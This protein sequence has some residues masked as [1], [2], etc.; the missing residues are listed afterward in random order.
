M[1]SN[2]Q[3][4]VYPLPVLVAQAATDVALVQH[5]ATVLGRPELNALWT[6][7]CGDVISDTEYNLCVSACAY[8]TTC[9]SAFA[10]TSL[11]GHRYVASEAEADSEQYSRKFLRWTVLGAANFCLL[12]TSVDATV[13]AH[14][15][16]NQLA[17]WYE[18]AGANPATCEPS[19]N[20]LSVPATTSWV[21]GRTFVFTGVHTATRA[22]L[23]QM[24]RAHG[25][26]VK[27]TVNGK[28]DFLVMGD[29]RGNDW[30]VT[31]GSKYQKVL[32][33][34]RTRPN[35]SDWIHVITE[36]QLR[37]MVPAGAWPVAPCGAPSDVVPETVAEDTD[38]ADTMYETAV[39]LCAMGHSVS[40]TR[41]PVSTAVQRS[42][43]RR[44]VEPPSRRVTRSMHARDLDGNTV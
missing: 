39:S 35:T 11:T 33:L 27:G 44:R 37:R 6:D 5:L 1:P 42:S 26:N 18:C 40:I 38:E 16:V 2:Y 23:T 43:K 12:D 14:A 25:A 30:V 41:A 36:D 29:P 8:A 21:V 19:T 24:L 15:A 31:N 34:H 32:A 3:P 7:T 4:K 22:S 9:V 13:S 28:T 10:P 20:A 17:E